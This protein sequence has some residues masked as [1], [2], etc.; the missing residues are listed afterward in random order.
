MRHILFAIPLGL[1]AVP[2]AAAAPPPQGQIQIPPELTDPEFAQRI[3]AMTK[4]L[5]TAVLDLPVGQIEAAAEGRPATEADRRRT[6]RDV[7]GVTDRQVQHQIAVSGPKIQAAV[8]AL[9]KSL[10]AVSRALSDAQT[11][12]ERAVANMPRPDY[13]KR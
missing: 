5:S 6:V 2:A 3:G 13:P 7:A 4:A 11:E 8:E 12:I 10:P 1:A 9:Q